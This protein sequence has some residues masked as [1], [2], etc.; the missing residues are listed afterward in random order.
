M[1]YKMRG[2]LRLRTPE[3][4]FR[5]RPITAV[6]HPRQSFQAGRRAVF[7]TLTSLVSAKL[8]QTVWERATLTEGAEGAAIS[9]RQAAGQPHHFYSGQRNRSKLKRFLSSN[10]TPS[11][12]SKRCWKASLPWRERV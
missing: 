8:K 11:S 1:S 9:G 4:L 7:G 3:P 12:F 5:F 10:S 2:S 6:S